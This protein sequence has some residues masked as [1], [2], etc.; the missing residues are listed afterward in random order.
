MYQIKEAAQLSRC[1]CQDPTH[2]TRNRTL[3]FL[4]SENVSNLQSKDLQP[5]DSLL[6]ISRLSLETIAELL[7][8]KRI[9]YCLFIRQLAI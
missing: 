3:G 7:R 1:L 8:K 9:V 6:Q 4:K 2:V 5:S